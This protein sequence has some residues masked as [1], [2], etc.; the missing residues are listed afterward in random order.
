[1]GIKAFGSDL[2]GSDESPHRYNQSDQPEVVSQFW[3]NT[4]KLFEHAALNF[5]FEPLVE[6]FLSRRGLD[7]NRFR[8]LMPV[9][10]HIKSRLRGRAGEIRTAA[11]S[12]SDH[13]IRKQIWMAASPPR[14]E[15]RGTLPR[16]F[17]RKRL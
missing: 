13:G 6:V 2:T 12:Q 1:L 11:K 15:I 17:T 10:D 5:H 14:E 4:D 8:F 3:Q 7:L 16:N 9:R